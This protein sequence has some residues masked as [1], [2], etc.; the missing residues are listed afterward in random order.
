M[1]TLSPYA[2]CRPRFTN[3]PV[4]ASLFDPKATDFRHQGDVHVCVATLF[5]ADEYGIRLYLKTA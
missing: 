1:F 3:T 5:Y 2:A 4:K